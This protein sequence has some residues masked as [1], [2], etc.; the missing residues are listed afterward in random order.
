QLADLLLA[1]SGVAP[2]LHELEIVHH[3][4]ADTARADTPL[5][6]RDFGFE[7]PDLGAQVE[8]RERRRIVEPEREAGEA[9][10]RLGESAPI[11]ARERAAADARHVDARLGREQ[12]RG[13]LLLRHFERAEQDARAG[14]LGG[15]FE[16]VLVLRLAHDAAR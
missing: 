6:A 5:P 12:T 15:G 2:P 11:L 16:V 13:E 1:A 9:R 7:S 8:Q 14:L 4:E 3:D 10:R